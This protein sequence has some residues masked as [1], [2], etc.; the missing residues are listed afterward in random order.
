MKRVLTFVMLALIAG[1]MLTACSNGGSQAELDKIRIGWQTLWATQGQVVKSLEHTN[2]LAMNGL[3]A[4]YV[5][6]DYGPKLN[7]LALAGGVDVILT[8][9][10][11]AAALLASGGEWTIIG[12]LMYNSTRVY[13][14]TDSQIESMADLMGGTVAGPTGAAAERITA[15]GIELA[16]LDPLGVNWI[17]LEMPA[18]SGIILQ[19]NNWPSDAMY[20]F[21]P[22]AANFV[23]QGL[24]REL[25]AGHVVS[26]V[27][28]SN[29]YLEN[30]PKAAYNFAK[31]FI[32][33]WH[34]YATHQEQANA[35]FKDESR[36]PFDVEV[37]DMAALVEPNINAQSI[38]DLRPFFS[39]D[40][41]AVLQSAA[42]FV[43][44]RA[45]KP[46]ITM[47]DFIDQSI[48]ERAFAELSLNYDAGQ[49]KVTK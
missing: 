17:T 33:A 1:V 21:D 12:R 14:P 18:Q 24:A 44:E 29:D 8:A 35:W 42:K 43:S 23:Y 6:V 38:N 10:Q 48:M 40:D 20:G 28:M 30:H 36:I 45:D 2:I 41:L 9:D 13:V 46:L 7:P 25:Y 26:V 19:G 3:E 49:V 11:P 4:T 34:Y 47:S 15:E 5:G 31:S 27:V 37:L 39:A 32:Q 22:A 16:G